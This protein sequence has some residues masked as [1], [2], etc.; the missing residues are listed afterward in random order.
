M[1][2][3]MRF[4]LCLCALGCMAVTCKKQ[5][6]STG[7]PTNDTS[8]VNLTHLNFLYTPVSFSGR[9]T[10]GIFIYAEAPDYHVVGASGEGF[11]CVDDVARAAQVYLRSNKYASDTSIRN[12]SMNLIRFLLEMQ[13]F[14]GYFYNFLYDNNSINTNGSTSANRP[15]WWSW[16]AFYTLTES[17]PVIRNYDPLLADKIDASIARMI[18]NIKNDL[19]LLPQNTK[20]VKGITIPQWLPAGSG[21]DQASLIILG[22]INYCSVHNDASLNAYIKK[23]ADGLLIMQNGDDM[24]FPYSAIMSW[25]NTWHAYGSDQAFAL[26]EAGI[27]LHDAGYTSKGMD[28]VNN[29]YPWLINNGFKSTFEVEKNNN[30][31]SL[32][33]EKSYEQIAYGIRPML[34]AVCEAYRMTREEKY[35]DM[36]GH[37]ASWYFGNN[38]ANKTMYSLNTGRCFDGIQSSS[39]INLNSGAESTIEA[40]LSMELIEKYPTILIALNK[41]KK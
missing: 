6:N 15:D 14:N 16:R 29:F 23:L 11:T 25:E 13:S 4:F 7:K 37:I 33:N 18:S 1:K 32:S 30:A 3:E 27:F 12:K 34:S 24:H 17:A 39:S 9:P 28:V 36:A 31:V 26:I 10:G 35:A 40:L 20:V 21:T 19:I 22:L 2:K 41:Y 5:N 38:N 8:I